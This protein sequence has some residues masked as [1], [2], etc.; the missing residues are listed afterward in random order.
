LKTPMLQCHGTDDPVVNP[1]FGEMSYKV[2]K[3]LG[4]DVTFEKYEGMGHN[5]SE[6]ELADVRRWIKTRIPDIPLKKE[7]TSNT[8]SA[9]AE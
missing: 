8:E 7:E 1:K 4:F 3:D 9:K 5:A 6:E 2:M